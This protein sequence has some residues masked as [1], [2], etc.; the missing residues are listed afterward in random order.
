MQLKNLIFAALSIVAA[1]CSGV[2]AICSAVAGD[3]WRRSSRQKAVTL[4]PPT[5][6]I[7]DNVEE[8]VQTERVNNDAL[9]AALLDSATLNEIAATW[10][11]RAAILAAI[12]A[13][14]AGFFAIA[15][16]RSAL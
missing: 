9:E 1:L 16:L 4:P 6:S 15:A 7:S 13:L 2:A 8:H 5:G 11:V 12:A 14:L 10:S 3:Y